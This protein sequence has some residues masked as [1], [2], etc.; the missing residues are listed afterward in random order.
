MKKNILFFFVVFTSF[1]GS[2]CAQNIT[3]LGSTSLSAKGNGIGGKPAN[4]N[5]NIPAGSNRVMI[6]HFWFERDHRPSTASNYP[7]GTLGANF[8]PLTVGGV[9]MAGK[10][11]LRT[12]HI[13][14]SGIG[15]Q[16]NA[17]LN[18]SFYR[19]TISDSQGLPTGAATFDFSG[20]LT[21]MNVADE[22]AVS[23]EVYGNVSPTSPLLAAGS[24]SWL[25]NTAATT[26]FSIT[27]TAAT[28]PI[29]RLAADVMYVGF[30][31]TSKDENISISSGWTTINN[32]RVD[33]TAGSSFNGTLA[34]EADG[35]SLL[36]AYR[37]GSATTTLTKSSSQSI[38]VVRM[39]I[40]PLLPL[41]KPSISG[42]VY[43]DTDG[44]ANINGSDTNGGGLYVNLVDTN[45]ILVYT[46]P[47]SASGAYTIPSGYAIEG[48]VYK[49]QLSKNTGTVGASAPLQELNS[50]WATVGEATSATGNDGNSDGIFNIT[51]GTTNSTVSYGIKACSAGTL[52]PAVQNLTINCPATSINLASA[53]IGT[54]PVGSTLLWFNNDSH[55]GTALSGTQASQAVAGIY[56]AFYYD[57]S[58]M[59]YSPSSNKVT[60]FGYSNL[61]NDGDGIADFCDLD[62]DNDG[63]LDTDE[64]KC[65]SSARYRLDQNATIAG[66]T[67]N[68]NGG[69]FNLVFTLESGGTPVPSIGNQFTI[70]FSYS[71][72]SGSS[73][74]W[75]GINSIGTASFAIRPN[76]NSLYT[77]LPANNSTSETAAE[78]YPDPIFNELLSTNKINQLGTYSVTIGSPPV[79][80]S[81][82]LATLSQDEFTLHSAWNLTYN[83]TNYTSGYYSRLTIQNDLVDY[84]NFA[85][86]EYL[87]VKY[88]NTYTY[89]YTAFSNTPGSGAGNGGNRGFIQLRDVIVE[90]CLDR[91]TDGDGIPDYLD[92]DSDNDG[93]LDA[94]E[95]DENVSNSQLVN[96]P[97]TLSVGTGS[98]A[99][100][101][102]LGN[103]VNANGVP[104][105]VNSGGA[106]DIGA[107]QGQ[108]VGSSA[109]A[110]VNTCFC[111]KP[112]ILDAGN[113]YPTKHGITALGRAGAENDNW[114]MVRQS[115]W[116]VLEAKTKGFVVNR[117]AFSDADNNPATPDVPTAISASNFVEGMM[118]YDSTNKCL[119]VYTSKNG[120][121]S[122]AWYCMTTQACPQ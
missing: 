56:Y 41:A 75:E 100:N 8:F 91:D 36:T 6:V 77:G 63:I 65:N 78:I 24:N 39:N 64:G 50:G 68:P 92:L 89:L 51:I 42:N 112:G 43:L 117:V 52:A 59:C 47:V 122:F 21:P 85:E 96:A 72:M 95:G 86:T 22:V 49:L 79:P 99:G 107:D 35:I 84:G 121:T 14:N 17:Q 32:V 60:I 23:I 1:L 15:D 34:N 80:V 11:V 46:A 93:C 10:S 62:D 88:G 57:S 70:P 3:L 83:G 61:D 90:Y 94:I 9:N 26:M 30:G 66:A 7:S 109:N 55:T 28:T 53:H 38:G 5:W 58:G 18:S 119:K 67:I 97:A 102:N 12:F 33:N 73:D 110:V 118:V 4:V 111:Y 104:N 105:V 108:G 114:P 25:E 116:T 31:G 37:N 71:G 76:T 13:V 69:S 103:T 45:D 101:Q 48:E 82:D 81:T 2:L 98:T 54:V 29:G 115:A 27:P 16:N 120:G 20:I 40:V 113:T 74:L 19:Y 87:S 44:S 106:A